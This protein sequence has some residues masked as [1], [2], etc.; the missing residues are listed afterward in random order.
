[1]ATEALL[2]SG[3]S[4]IATLRRK[5]ERLELFSSLLENY[6]NSLEIKELDLSQAD[7][8]ESLAK[9][10]KAEN[11]SL[12][13]LINNAGYGQ[14]G[15]LLDLSRDDL[16][17][18]FDANFFGPAHLTKALLPLLTSP[19]ARVLN[20]SSVL[21][22]TTMPLSAAYSSSK[23][24]LEAFFESTRMEFKK[25]GVQ[26]C[27]IQPGAFDTQ[28]HRNLTWGSESHPRFESAR[29]AFEKFRQERREKKKNGKPEKVVGEIV[30]LST[31]AKI[32]FRVRI[33]ADAE[34]A[35]WSQRLLPQSLYLRLSELIFSSVLKES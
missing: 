11:R 29:M 12:Y 33:G 4:V 8:I 34:L 23:H 15:A 10:L 13:A 25:L 2:R 6:P 18:Q 28:F 19:R 14:F 1:M 20:I 9:E 21:G 26:L 16:Q 32:P 27:M 7:Q 24:A 22:F 35:Y 30:R 3:F 5:Q 17:K 31:Q